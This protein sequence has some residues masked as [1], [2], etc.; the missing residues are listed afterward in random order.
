[1]T[2]L[3]KNV[4]G[5]AFQ[6]ANECIFIMTG[7]LVIQKFSSSVSVVEFKNLQHTKP[8]HKISSHFEME[9][10]TA[11]L[12]F[13]KFKVVHLQQVMYDIGA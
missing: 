3:V 12:T 13:P 7:A 6:I 11:I 5:S 1:M 4:S 10:F 2:C 9:I 8:R